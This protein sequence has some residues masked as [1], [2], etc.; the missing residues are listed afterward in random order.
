MLRPFLLLVLLSG[1]LYGQTRTVSLGISM[2]MTST[3]SWN[4]GIQKDPRYS[5]QYGL[6]WAPIMFQ[7]GVDYEGFGFVVSPGV[8]SVGQHHNVVNTVGGQQGIRKNKLTYFQLPV[9]LKVHLIDLSFFKVSFVAGGGVGYLLNGKE[10]I[11][12]EPNTKLW[13]PDEVYPLFPPTY[14]IEYDGIIVPETNE[15]LITKSDFKPLQFFALTGLRADWD[16]SENIRV[17]VDF[18]MHYG[19]LDPRGEDYINAVNQYQKLF[20]LPGKQRDT[21]AL[22]SVGVSRYMD[23]EPKKSTKKSPVKKFSKKNSRV[24][25]SKPRS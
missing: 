12:I 22:I 1:T 5:S 11:Y 18:Q 25:S 17:S 13:F 6:K 10:T 14:Q 8:L 2:G 7:Y 23:V 4:Q 24:R 20:D 3:Y 15:V 16:V 21:F 19:I 9:F